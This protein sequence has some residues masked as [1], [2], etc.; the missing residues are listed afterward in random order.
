MPRRIARGL[1]IRYGALALKSWRWIPGRDQT[2]RM[3][4]GLKKVV[5]EA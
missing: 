2:A 3:L 1:S 4:Q 5:D